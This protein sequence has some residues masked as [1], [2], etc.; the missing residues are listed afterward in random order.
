MS[1][2]LKPVR[3]FLAV[4]E[5]Q[6]FAAAARDLGLA[7]ASVTRIVAQLERD[8]GTQPL[9]RTTRKVSLTSAGALVAA[10]YRPLVADFDAIASELLD[11]YRPDRGTLRISAPVS[12][13]TQI[14]PRILAGFRRAYP[15]VSVQ[16]AL[17]DALVDVMAETCDLAIRVSGPP[18]DLSTIWRKL[19]GAPR[20]AVAAPDLLAR[21]GPLEDPRALSPEW[22]LSYGP[23]GARELW[24]FSQAGTTRSHRAGGHI[25]CDNGDV[26]LG[27][28]REG[29]GIAV[30]PDFITAE[31]RRRGEV[32]VV[33]PDW[34]LPAL[35]LTLAYPPYAKMP[36]LVGLFADHVEAHLQETQHT[37]RLGVPGLSP[38]QG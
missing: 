2:D 10:R 7:P 6:S 14:L 26:L 31:A 5:R 22:T 17:T 25:T 29:A 34:E 13:G 15:L 11:D 33:L 12:L 23:P 27:L 19:C 4:A 38:A 16:V 37:G 9:L 30:L 18:R 20:H 36:P 21:I 24:E 28:V 8:L 32:V 35:W 3:V 1:L